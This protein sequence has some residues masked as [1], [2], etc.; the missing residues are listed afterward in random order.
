MVATV[1]ALK[2]KT[3]RRTRQARNAHAEEVAKDRE[4][5]RSQNTS[6]ELSRTATAFDESSQRPSLAQSF[7]D[8]SSVGLESGRIVSEARIINQK[9]P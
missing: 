4:F 1:S 6:Y 8:L 7:M 3:P 2:T 9:T 5:Q